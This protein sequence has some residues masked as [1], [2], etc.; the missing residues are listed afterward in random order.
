MTTASELTPQLA[1]QMYTEGKTVYEIAVAS[2]TTYSKA[3][4]AIVASGTPI[5]NASDRLKGRTRSPKASA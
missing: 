4:K 5:R 2:G 3:R 1:A